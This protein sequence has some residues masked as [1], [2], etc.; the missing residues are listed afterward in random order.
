MKITAAVVRVRSAP[1]EIETLDLAA[2]LTDEVLVRVV[3]MRLRIGTC[4][5]D[6]QELRAVR[7]RLVTGGRRIRTCMGLFLSS[8]IFGL[9]PVLCSERESRSSFRCLR[10]GS[11]SGRKGSRDRNGSKAWRLAA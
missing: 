10:S 11:R 9:L 7:S 8:R 2:P 6:A 3:T 5:M 4:C 1:F